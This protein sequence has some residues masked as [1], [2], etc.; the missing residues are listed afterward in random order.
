MPAL[1]RRVHAAAAA[2]LVAALLAGCASTPPPED[3]LRKADD[4][5]EAAKRA[6]AFRLA[7]DDLARARHEVAAAHALA[8]AHRFEEAR[9]EAEQAEADAGVARANAQAR[10]AELLAARGQA[11]ADERERQRQELLARETEARRAA[12]EAARLA[13]LEAER[14]TALTRE[15]GGLQARRTDR[16]VIVTLGDVLFPTGSATLPVRARRSAE[17][18]AAVLQQHPQRRIR[19]EGHTDSVGSA[20][21]N[22]ALSRRRALALRQALLDAGV[23]ASRI[24]FVAYG[25]SRPVADNA[26]STGRQQNR[27]VEL[28]FSDGQGRLPPP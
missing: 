17:R 2:A 16:G 19:I 7:P 5:Y 18:V 3:A 24:E 15:L 22:L 28:L 8:D 25:E 12:A 10:R 4:A 9:R 11:G 27:R 1:L 14:A 26:T 21:M 6:D 23:E 13:A 20:A